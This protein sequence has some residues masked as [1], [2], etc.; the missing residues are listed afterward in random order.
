VNNFFK[1]NSKQNTRN[2]FISKG[3]MQLMFSRN[4]LNC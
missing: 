4:L 3:C 2:P 1:I